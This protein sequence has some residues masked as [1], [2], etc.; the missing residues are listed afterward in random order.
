MIMKTLEY[1]FDRERFFDYVGLEPGEMVRHFARFISN[2]WQVH[3][4]REGNTRTTAVFAIKYLNALGFDVTNDAFF[5]NSWYFR[6]A[7]VRAHYS[8]VKKGVS[9]NTEFLELFFRNLLGEKNELKN[10]Y[11]HIEAGQT[12]KNLPVNK[13]CSRLLS[14]LAE[15]PDYTYEDLAWEI[16]KTRETV[17]TSLR[18]LE[19]L[20]LI[21]RIGSDKKGHWKIL[22]PH[23]T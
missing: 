6:N 18:K 4:F 8:N 11:L 10:R 22:L 5:D 2:I 9:L 20:N 3:P 19:A 17:R 14:L 16:G 7:L 1:D 13:T 15:H 23:T 12:L 21:R